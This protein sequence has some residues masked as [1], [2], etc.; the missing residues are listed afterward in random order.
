MSPLR[1]LLQPGQIPAAVGLRPA[2]PRDADLLWQWR[3]EWSVRRFQPLND[4]SSGQ[5]R[6]EI[7]HQHVS[8]LY[9]GRGEKFQW[10]VVAEGKPA[11]WITLAVSN[12]DHGLAEVGYA[13]SSAFQGR[14]LMSRALAQLIADLFHNTALKRLEARCAIGNEASKRVLERLGFRQEGVLRGY[15]ELR[16]R[17]VDNLLFALLKGDFLAEPG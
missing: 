8:E 14:G 10:I 15:F 4:L 3:S 13:L 17:R 7:L 2:V 1:R 6:T 12:W 5:L 11:G 16:G 9:Q